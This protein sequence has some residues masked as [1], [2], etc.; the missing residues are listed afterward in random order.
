MEPI[1]WE[2]SC[3]DGMRTIHGKAETDPEIQQMLEELEAGAVREAQEN[4]S[5][6][7]TKTGDLTVQQF[8]A[9][10]SGEKE[11]VLALLG[12]LGIAQLSVPEDEPV[13]HIHFSGHA[14][15]VFCCTVISVL[16]CLQQL[17]GTYN[18]VF[19]PQAELEIDMPFRADAGQMQ[20]GVLIRRLFP[21]ITQT[22]F[23]AEEQ[24]KKG[25]FA[26]FFRKS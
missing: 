4:C 21:W 5:L 24:N 23:R 2:S 20:A 14:Q 3:L 12:S 19:F 18:I 11:E 13:I 8:D 16:H 22:D 26:R 17:D 1:V 10:P 7:Q 6:L 9:M 15:R 25:F